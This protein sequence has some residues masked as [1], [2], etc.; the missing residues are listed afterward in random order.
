MFV[1]TG[2]YHGVVVKIFSQSKKCMKLWRSKSHASKS[3]ESS[4]TM[5][6]KYSQPW[7]IRCYFCSVFDW[8]GKGSRS[9]YHKLWSV[10]LVHHPHSFALSLI[11]CL[12]LWHTLS[13]SHMHTA[14]H[15]PENSR[16]PAWALTFSLPC[17]PLFSLKAPKFCLKSPQ[18]AISILTS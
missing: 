4:D 6:P 7:E 5:T 17:S 15:W 16:I 18:S 9:L 14:A 12:S 10:L 1:S 2:H 3:Q 11:L 8:R 13:H